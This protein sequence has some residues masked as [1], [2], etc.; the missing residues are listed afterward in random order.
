MNVQVTERLDLELALRF[1]L[2]EG[3]FLL[4]YQPKM[5]V[6]N[7]H[8]SGVEA[9]LRWERPG[10]GLVQPS[11]FIPVMEQTGLIVRVGAWVIDAACRQIAEWT[12]AGIADM[13]VAVN[14]SS[15]Q[16]SE[17]DLEDEIR[18]ALE[19]HQVDPGLL[20][21]ELTESALMLNTARTVEVL[22]RLKRLG[23]RI[24]IDDFGTG[25]SSLAY[26]KRFPIDK[27][28]I[29]IAFVRD[30]TTNPDDAAI[31]LAIISMAHSMH[32]EVIAEGVESPAQL[33]YF[34]KHHCDEIQGYHF[35]R[36]LPAGQVARMVLANRAQPDRAPD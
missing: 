3:Q 13:R 22:E 33:A 15:R 30:V 26:L 35:S 7:G 27:L 36:P 21:I 18:G 31:A 14:V 16:F 25:Y 6:E 9:L 8:V 1:A 11:D 23:I 32:M 2:D 19:R 20:E 5:H 12:A 24:A 28:K 4:Y 10:H 34:G 29:D 17:G